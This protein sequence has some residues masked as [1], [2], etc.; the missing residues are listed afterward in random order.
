MPIQD[1]DGVGEE[2]KKSQMVPWVS[3]NP[4]TD[5]AR[6]ISRNDPNFVTAGFSYILHSFEGVSTG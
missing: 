6:V 5:P 3:P 4:W 2:V 1:V